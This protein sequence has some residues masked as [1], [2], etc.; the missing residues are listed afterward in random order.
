MA[1]TKHI[2][3]AGIVEIWIEEV[4]ALGETKTESAIDEEFATMAETFVGT[5]KADHGISKALTTHN[6]G[7]EGRD[8]EISASPL[9]DI[10]INAMIVYRV[11]MYVINHFGVDI[12]S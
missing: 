8:F 9:R 2:P 4:D 1:F 12:Y 3:E 10:I 11:R 5:L 7:V 6:R